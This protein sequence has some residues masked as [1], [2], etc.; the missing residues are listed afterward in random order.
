MSN[1]SLMTSTHFGS[2][3][4]ASLLF[5]TLTLDIKLSKSREK[6]ILGIIAILNNYG[7]SQTQACTYWPR[8]TCIRS[9]DP[10]H[11]VLSQINTFLDLR[12]VAGAH[13]S[14]LPYQITPL[15]PPFFYHY[16][17]HWSDGLTVLQLVVSAA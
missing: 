15:L 6:N 16:W 17:C 2:F 13:L 10:K 8:H 7:K 5:K 11:P 4:L 12:L 3:C 1:K 14:T 9:S